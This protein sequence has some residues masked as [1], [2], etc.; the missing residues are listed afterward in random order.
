VVV[1]LFGN[2][3]PDSNRFILVTPKPENGVRLQATL[4]NQ[5]TTDLSVGAVRK[6]LGSKKMNEKELFLAPPKK[7]LEK[8][9]LKKAPPPINPK[10]RGP[11]SSFWGT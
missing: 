3:S 9:Y 6:S 11:K 4:G 1:G 5:N 7:Y 2:E 10:K 8:K